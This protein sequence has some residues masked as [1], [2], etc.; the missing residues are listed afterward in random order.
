MQ[1]VTNSKLLADLHGVD[2]Y[3]EGVDGAGESVDYWQSL[4]DFWTAYFARTGATLERYSMLRNV[5][6][7]DRS[8]STTAD[9]R[10]K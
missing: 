1:R 7:L 5:P 3:A 9:T 4:H 8:D 6:D 2:V 10:K